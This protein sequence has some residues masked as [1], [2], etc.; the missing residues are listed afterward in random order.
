MVGLTFV[1][2][3]P[4]LA[5]LHIPPPRIASPLNQPSPVPKYINDLFVGFCAIVVTARLSKEPFTLYQIG[6]TAVPL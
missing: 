6:L 4:L 1:H 5:D 3:S 2:V